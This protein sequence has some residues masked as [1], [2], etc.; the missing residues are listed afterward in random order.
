MSCNYQFD[1]IRFLH[2]YLDH[3]PSDLHNLPIWT[4]W[5]YSSDSRSLQVLRWTKHT[6]SISMLLS[7][8]PYQYDGHIP[9][10]NL[11]LIH[12]YSAAAQGEIQGTTPTLL[13]GKICPAC[14]VDVDKH[15]KSHELSHATTVFLLL[16][17]A[18]FFSHGLGDELTVVT[19][20]NILMIINALGY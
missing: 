16:Q 8:R 9:P 15:G 3:K 19:R 10:S 14:I 2:F 12:M 17:V 13:S 6:Y 18:C 4:S 20:L 1:Y 11:W 7:L 5:N